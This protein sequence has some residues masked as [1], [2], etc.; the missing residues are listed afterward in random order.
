MTD[1]G[2]TAVGTI[3]VIGLIPPR[4]PCPP[5]R[6]GLSVVGS[7]NSTRTQDGHIRN[8]TRVVS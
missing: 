5:N 1:G 7:V 8:D 2:Q 3:A 6:L 4:S